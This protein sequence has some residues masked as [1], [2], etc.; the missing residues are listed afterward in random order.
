MIK[1]SGSVRY[2]KKGNSRYQ[3]ADDWWVETGIK[4]WAA[5]LML[6]SKPLVVLDE[7]GRLTVYAGYVFDG[8]SGPTLNTDNSMRG[9]T[10]HD[11]LYQL[12]REGKIPPSVRGKADK[13]AW[14]IWRADGMS[15]LRAKIWLWA[16]RRFAKSAYTYKPEKVYEAG[17]AA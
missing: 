4:N 11:A 6:G 16:L 13:L 15:W 9:A 12:A 7:G 8:P 2:L 3:I 10:A 5:R 17:R 1:S 14:R